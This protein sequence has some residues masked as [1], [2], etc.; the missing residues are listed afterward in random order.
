MVKKMKITVKEH[1]TYGVKKL[2]REIARKSHEENH[3]NR[4]IA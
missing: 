1:E 2:N 4:E 3:K